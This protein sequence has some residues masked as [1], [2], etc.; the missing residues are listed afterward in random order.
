ML[1]LNLAT[2][3]VYV[4]QV[5]FGQ[6]LSKNEKGEVKLSDFMLNLFFIKSIL[7]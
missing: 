5:H 6:T 7:R 3:L 1:Y 4:A 2:G